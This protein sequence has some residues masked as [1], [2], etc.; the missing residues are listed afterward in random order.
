MKKK[1]IIIIVAI[2]AIIIA[3]IIIITT[4]KEKKVNHF[5]FP[6]TLTASNYTNYERADT[7]TMV[8]LNRIFN[9][10]TMQISIH[11]MVMDMGNDE[12]ETWAFIQKNPFVPH[13]YYIFIKDGSLPMS[14]EQLLSHELIHLKQ[15]E[16][17]IL[18]VTGGDGYYYD[19][20]YFKFSEVPYN[21]RPQEIEAFKNQNE[22]LR[23]LN[24][25]LYS[26]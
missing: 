24:D 1:W 12:L 25:L 8:I 4:C 18:V 23:K 15:I 14:L 13:N 10:D 21:Q 2:L 5:E 7:I 9:I 16:S 3:T 20:K 22:V 17:G 6:S 11:K 19:G 26:K